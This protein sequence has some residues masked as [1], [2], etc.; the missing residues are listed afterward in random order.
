MHL[1]LDQRMGSHDNVRFV[2][3][4]P[5]VGCALFLC[6]HGAGYQDHLFFDAVS[7]KKLCDRFIMLLC[8]HLRRCHQGTLAAVH[9]SLQ[10]CK[11]SNDGFAGAYISLDQAVHDQ[12]TLQIPSHLVQNFF[13]C[14]GQLIGQGS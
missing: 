7:I 8:Q 11:H 2:S 1:F 10:E 6:S 14:S 12:A 13:L 4:D 5:F 3:G 9:G